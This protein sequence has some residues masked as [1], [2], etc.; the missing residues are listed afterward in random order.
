MTVPRATTHSLVMLAAKD[1]T[2]ADKRTPGGLIVAATPL[3]S[4]IRVRAPAPNISSQERPTAALC[5]I[6]TL[7]VDRMIG[8]RQTRGHLDRGR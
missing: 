6:L 5:V 7:S 4:S 3:R 2:A 8:V 1:G